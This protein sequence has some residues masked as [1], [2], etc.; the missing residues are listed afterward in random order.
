M[1]GLSDGYFVVPYTMQNYLSDQIQVPHISTDLP[2]FVEAE[3]AV[4][5]EMD[6]IYNIQNQQQ[7][8]TKLKSV[9]SLHKE[10]YNIMWNYVGMARSAEG[11]KKALEMLKEVRKQ[12]DT[13]VRIPGSK[14]GLNV[15]LDKAIHLRDFI[16]MGELIAYDALERNESCGGHFR[17]ES[18]TEEG[19]AK[20]DDEHYMYVAC[21][22]YA[23]SDEAAPELLKEDLDYQYIKV[24]TRN[25]KS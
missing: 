3:K 20:R 8:K 14:E 4:Q 7:D 2:E 24:Q 6:R 21:W 23:G 22:K 15:E 11:L 13:C 5:A 25:Y 9:D 10:L 12:F 17:E 18:Q 16:T 1:Q 19:E